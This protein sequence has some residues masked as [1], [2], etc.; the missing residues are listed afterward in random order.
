M[1]RASELR[2]RDSSGS[3]EGFSDCSSKKE[4]SENKREA[5]LKMCTNSAHY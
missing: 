3:E 1:G 2:M 5:A 4:P